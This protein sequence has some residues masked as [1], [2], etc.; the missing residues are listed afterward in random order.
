MKVAERIETP[1]ANAAR[2]HATIV[3]V[4]AMLLAVAVAWSIQVLQAPLAGQPERAVM[5][6]GVLLVAILAAAPVIYLLR[7]GSAAQPQTAGLAFLSA[8]A[9]VL[10]GIYLFRVRWYVTF[11]ADIWV[12]SEGDFINDML[13][14]STGFPMYTDPSNLDST[15]YPPVPQLLTYFLAWLTGHSQSIPVFRA[16]QL[17][18]TVLASYVALLCCRRILKMGFPE[19][20][21]GESIL[22]N[23]FWFSALFLMATNSITNRF[24]HNLHGDALAQLA[25]MMSLY[26]LLVY[27]ETRSPRVLAAMVVFVPFEF[28]IKQNL[29]IW[30]VFYAGYLAVWGRSFK[31]LAIYCVASVAIFG[32]AMAVCQAVWGSPFF[33]WIFTELARHAVSPL[34][35]FQHLLDSWAYFAAGLLGGAAI[36]R[37]R[38]PELLAAWLVWLLFLGIETY[39]SGIEWM[40][41]HMGSG[42]L[43]AGIWFLAGLAS[44][45]DL[46]TGVFRRPMEGWVRAAAVT[47]T[48]A[49]LLAGMGLVRI[50]L[51]PVSGDLYRYVNDIE[52]QFVG[53][54]A[55]KVL[56]DEGV[57]VYMKDRIVTRDHSPAVGMLGMAKMP[58]GFAGIKSRI[59]EKRYARILVRDLHEHDFGYENELWPK[60]GGI[61][62]TL[63]ANYNEVGHIPAAVGPKEVKDW[64]EDPFLFSEITILEPK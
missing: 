22:W 55:G 51:K 19:S 49:L 12:W 29:V 18:Y 43:M 41:N 31:R 11:P 15:H 47:S 48:V 44:V 56:L 52:K 50:P 4:F 32:S 3:S 20:R 5:L 42:S 57:W 6:T 8:L 23:A 45:W 27:M 21:A 60:P 64:A 39:T 13:K 33:F 63:L 2:D 24:A 9:I 54:P 36:L 59:A 14:F 38:R 37:G 34:R 40:L 61:R 25:A 30:G 17:G 28:F 1:K 10:A 7:S 53:L 16:I 58:E 26:L 62:E 46:A 35:G